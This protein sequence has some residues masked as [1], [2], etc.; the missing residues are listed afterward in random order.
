[1]EIK[2]EIL[3][4][5]G[6]PTFLKHNDGNSE[7]KFDLFVLRSRKTIHSNFSTAFLAFVIA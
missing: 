7:L 6:F 5:N 3:K 1:M 2:A 4:W